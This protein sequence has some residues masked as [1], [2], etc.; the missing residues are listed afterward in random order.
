[1]ESRGTSGRQASSARKSRL[2]LLL[3]AANV[4]ALVGGENRFGRAIPRALPQGTASRGSATGWGRESNRADRCP[5]DEDG[6]RRADPV[7]DRLSAAHVDDVVP[8]LACGEVTTSET[9]MGKS[10]KAPANWPTV[11][12]RTSWGVFG[13]VAELSGEY[14]T[15]AAEIR[16]QWTRSRA[17]MSLLWPPY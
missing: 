3:N 6:R 17:S 13:D 2:S 8:V 9:A 16:R 5:E 7:L 12:T 15:E 10:L 4:T 11:S 14:Q 1:M